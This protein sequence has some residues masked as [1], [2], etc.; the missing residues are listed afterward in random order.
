MPIV[1]FS[2][3]SSDLFRTNED[4]VMHNMSL[5]LVCNENLTNV[6]KS[7]RELKKILPFINSVNMLFSFKY[8]F[9]LTGIVKY[10]NTSRIYVCC[11]VFRLEVNQNG[12]PK[13]EE[14]TCS[15]FTTLQEI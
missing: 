12:Y 14:R 7:T 15:Y 4:I 2:N 5:T 11:R 1:V 13:T 8:L 9:R 6:N 10:R 3:C